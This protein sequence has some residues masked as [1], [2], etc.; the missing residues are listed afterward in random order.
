[1]NA[2]FQDSTGGVSG[3]IF[4]P[5]YTQAGGYSVRLIA[6]SNSL[7]D[8][9]LVSITVTNVDRA[10]VL[11]TI[12]PRSVAE[13]GHLQ[14]R[15]TA[16]DPD[17]D[18]VTLLTEQIPANASFHDSTG[19]V[20]GFIFNPDYTQAGSYPVRFIAS[21][22][23]LTDTEL[24]TI[25]VNDLDRPPVITPV[26][27][28]TIPEGGH[29]A[30]RI[31]ASDPDAGNIITLLAQNLPTNAT[32]HDSTGGIGGLIFDPNYTQAASYVIRIIANSNALSDTELV[33]V[34]V[35]NTDRKPIL[36]PIS[37]QNLSEGGHLALRV[38]ASDPDGDLITLLAQQLPAN[39]S[40]HDSTGG[41]GGFLF[42]PDYS[43]AG[44]YQVRFIANSNLLADTQLVS[45]IVNNV[46]RPPA[47]TPITAQNVP[48]AGLL[49][50]RVASTDPDGDPITLIAENLPANASFHDSTGGFGG[51]IFNPD[52]TQAGPYQVRIIAT[53]N[54]LADTELVNI[55]V[56]N[57][58]R[59]PIF[60]DLGPQS[61]SE[62]QT[63]TVNMSSSDPDNDPITLT[64]G[65]L[66]AHATFT[67]LGGGAGRLIFNPDL[68]QEG[69]YNLSFYATSNSPALRD[70][71]LLSVDVLHTNAAPVLAPIGPKTVNENQRLSF[72]IAASDLDGQIPILTALNLP[73]HAVFT[74]S[75]N[76][77]GH[78]VFDPDFF[79]S[80]LYTVLFIAGDGA[81]SDSEYVDITVV[82][83]NRAPVL[84]PIG[85]R[86]VIEG[87]IISFRITSSDLDLQIP[88][89]I[90][91]NLPINAS[92]VDSANGSGLFR[93]APGYTQSGNYDIRFIASDGSLSDSE[94]V[95]I[96]VL[97]AG[98]QP[99]AIDSIAPQTLHEGEHLIMGIIARDPDS[100][101]SALQAFN[102]PQNSAF[103]DSGNGRGS[104]TFN[105]G[106]LQ[107]GSYSVLFRAFDGQYYDSLWVPITV[108]NA[109]LM[110][111]LNP[112]GPKV[113]TEAATL[114]F[115]VTSSD[116]DGSIPQVSASPLPLHA[117]FADSLNGHGL[118]RF[119]PDYTQSGSYTI[120]FI[121]SI[122]SLA[123]SE[124]VQVT[125]ND[126]GNQ[127]PVLSSIG[128]KSVYENDS[129]LFSI[130]AIDP[131]GNDPILTA[132]SLPQNASFI[133][134]GNGTGGFTFYPNYIQS[135]IYQVLF[136]ATDGALADSE[137]VPVTVLN[138]N[139]TPVLVDIG[140]Q[141][142]SEGG[143]LEFA[144]RSYDLDGTIPMLSASPLPLNATFEDST[145][146]AGLFHFQPDYSQAGDYYILF[147]AYDGSSIDSERVHITVLSN[148]QPPIFQPLANQFV[149]E[150][151]T[152]AFS[153]IASDPDGQSLVLTTSSLPLNASFTDNHNGTGAFYFQPDFT[154]SGVRIV[155]FFA[156]DGQSSDTLSIEITIFE[157]GNQRPILAFIGP[158][159]TN[160]GQTLQLHITSTDPDGN[161]P[162]MGA[163]HLPLNAYFEDL[164]NGTAIFTFT[165]DFDQAGVDTVLFY[166][167]D[168]MM[169]DS[170]R[171][172]ITV[173]NVN[174]PPILN[175]IGP[176]TLSE[177]DSLALS[178]SGSDPD[179]DSISFRAVPLAPH[180]VLVDNGHG[181]AN[182]G[183]KPGYTQGGVYNVIFIT[184]ETSLADSEI[185]QFTVLEAGNQPPD[186]AAIDTA[187]YVT[188][189]ESLHVSISAVDPDGNPLAL[190][191]TPLIAN[192]SFVDN[193]N[194]TGNFTFRPNFQQSGSYILKFLAYD[195]QAYDSASTRIYVA[196]QGN[197]YPILAP[198][199][200]R[201]V[202]EGDSLVINVSATDP[203]GFIPFLYIDNP[204]PI[205]NFV[206]LRNGTGR[207]IYHPN[208]YAAGAHVVR[209]IAMDNGGLTDYEDVTITVTDVN[210][211]PWIVFRGPTTVTEG[212]SIV[213]TV[214]AYDSTDFQPGTLSLAHGY[215]PPNAT[216][217]VIGNGIARFT[218]QPNYNQA[219]VDSAFFVAVDSDTP[220]LSASKWVY[221]RVLNSNRRPQ[222]QQVP[223]SEI[224]QGDSLT[225]N[226]L[227]IDPDGDPVTLFINTSN[228][229]PIPVNS[230]FEDLGGGIGRFRFHPDYT[231][232]GIYV[233][234]FAA[235]DGYLTD[236]KPGLIQVH[237]LGNQPPTLNPIGP[238]TLTE[239][240]SIRIHVVS[241]DPDSTASTLSVDGLI[242]GM[243]F[244]DSTNGRGVFRYTALYNHAG[245]HHLMFRAS[246]GQMADSED[247]TITVLEAGNQRPHLGMISNRT[248]AEGTT[249]RFG[250]IASDADSVNP[251][252]SVHNLPL[253]A[254][255]VDSS[256]SRGS[257]TFTPSYTQ[258]GIYTV[259]FLA[260]D[261]QYPDVIDSENVAITVTDVNRV[262][263][264]D[265]LGPFSVNEGANLAF[266][267]VSHDE[268]FTIPR[269]TVGHIPP[270][271]TF[272]DNGDGTGYFSFNPDYFQSGVDSARFYAIDAAD[273]NLFRL[274]TVRINIINV[275]R[276]P[277][278]APIPADT[279]IG[280]GFM[281][282]INVSATDPDLNY[283]IIFQRGKPDSA[284]FID[285]NNGTGRFQ[286]R[287]RY[288]DI[289][290]YHFYLGCRDR[291]NPAI[292]DSQFVTLHVI[293]AGNH[294]PIFV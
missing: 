75:L 178:I 259:T 17:G 51:L 204:P 105:P 143:L 139:R 226:L 57:V 227:A 2:S 206:D 211:S 164:G 265:S 123:D 248:I 60:V 134:N 24:V 108:L 173:V 107:A 258:A 52:Y 131:D 59:A 31:T 135:G 36:S 74:D 231:Q 71:L 218:F 224:N 216:F 162:M 48:E 293:S 203:E 18:A 46:D 242:P 64:S 63:L 53:S 171:V 145:T 141:S 95:R 184:S 247:V 228:Y 153:V 119:T 159:T 136:I 213:D 264:I 5:N 212:A 234:N 243:V 92:L 133:D 124:Y 144:V 117:T 84:N 157:A 214:T 85:N 116:P 94:L 82:N 42:D 275:N 274:R 65:T 22:A 193:N 255:F 33:F 140:P 186:L 163:S 100:T 76:G 113:V 89:L 37:A 205:S 270:N 225:L 130:S 40:F 269:L 11:A 87:N 188:E 167:T 110:P 147:S 73:P 244:S 67:D 197:Q 261:G 187:Y 158:Q 103:A 276:P 29:L 149:N 111:V 208:Y 35:T 148:N 72:N 170:E 109:P 10:P 155:D 161:E 165:P 4:D 183:F 8:T 253:N 13:G 152:L 215:M 294:P 97:E 268:D 62:G 70:T 126:A 281:L 50:V 221:F 77:R 217:T 246:D 104:F 1:A 3:L 175:P 83:V 238:Y 81:L 55:T 78:F 251:I 266:A 233:V 207:L 168:G 237:D 66:P 54:A 282:T 283:P 88:T 222:L 32:F 230:T 169:A 288:A 44:S 278:L 12:G 39:S 43:Q 121:A 249:L 198:I 30:L 114:Q 172:L 49:A 90:A 289:G 176:Y 260:T 25:T 277:V 201:T 122:G 125:V 199:G 180:M 69:L 182:F 279:S 292:S 150:G 190:S 101:I 21:S 15:V 285:N 156:S 86:S 181:T 235:T 151:G 120:L 241:T 61:V 272:L 14:I 195:G 267:V 96:T 132:I 209:F 257:F 256:N 239:G 28:Q 129:L 263:T 68:T 26:S 19:G 56:T 194:G 47:I 220:P 174:R 166:A 93:F 229:P 273:P 254:S 79:Q 177:G 271:S 38:T 189:G 192:M 280:D 106:F 27:S 250:V 179:G 154:Q 219:G 232:S 286:W 291:T 137:T 287:P 245:V 91:Q 290:T 9:Q 16:T 252:L 236:T 196:E 23:G 210:R 115:V 138:V 185:V 98:N 99:P 58:D 202:A 118:F 102:L 223:P 262:P 191:A 41:A 112:I 6:S 160:E 127:P 7:A 20:G 34:T 200:P 146:G 284:S 128:P 45:I 80:G 142:V 240:D